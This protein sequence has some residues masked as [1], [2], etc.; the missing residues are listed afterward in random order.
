MTI[1]LLSTADWNARLWTNKQYMA[2]ELAKATD[3]IYVE[4]L[5]LRRP[6]LTSRDLSRMRDRLFK[7]R[8]SP[9]RSAAQRLAPL[10]LDVV[11]PKVVPLHQWPT[12]TIN[13]WL[14]GRA[15]GSWRTEQGPRLLWTY[16]PET[17]GL[18]VGVP[19]V[20]H[21]VDF[22][23]EVP[24]VDRRVIDRGERVLAAAGAVAI[25]SSWPIVHHLAEIGFSDV[26]YWPNVA[27]SEQFSCSAEGSALR[28]P[29]LVVF[30]GNLT[31][32][33]IDPAL[34]AAVKRSRP[35]ARVVMAGPVADI[36]ED[37]PWID[38][39]REMGVE[40]PGVMT[41]AELARLFGH[42]SV[43]VIPYRINAYTR[44][45]L[46]LK[47]NEYLAAG[48]PVVASCLPA[49]D[50]VPKDVVR[51]E[52]AERFAEAVTSQLRPMTEVDIHRRQALA[53]QNSWSS[54]GAEARDLV[55]T[56]L[57]QRGAHD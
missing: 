6:G 46:P 38:A 40:F 29:N 36:S 54:R 8:T 47:V 3:V 24:G 49:L 53:R 31:S 1:L 39:L 50:D 41:V 18:H 15:C 44:G 56:L 21:C 10:R 12:K 7:P 43:G 33:K 34:V 2:T 57:G 28:D 9:P 23:A 19:T 20:Y 52:T 13:S 55:A 17:Y 4:S 32:H 16:S 14:L 26:R 35:S 27:D 30:G 37:T 25:G 48:L 22:L 5:G 11:S 42:A 45:V 51:A